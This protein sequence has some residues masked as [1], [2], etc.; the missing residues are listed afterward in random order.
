MTS[1]DKLEKL[2]TKDNAFDQFMDVSLIRDSPYAT[3]GSVQR[4]AKMTWNC[5]KQQKG[6]Q[7]SLLS[8]PKLCKSDANL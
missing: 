3:A 6:M 5:Q 4:R 2:S 1:Y 8:A 7:V